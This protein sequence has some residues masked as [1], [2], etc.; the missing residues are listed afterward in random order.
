MVKGDTAING[1]A[2]RLS[3]DN[4]LDMVILLIEWFDIL[5]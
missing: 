4:D 1:S 5:L 3:T 2:K